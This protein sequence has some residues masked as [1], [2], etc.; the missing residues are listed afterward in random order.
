MI[1]IA[2]LDD[3]QK[4][5]HTFA[6]WGDL[7][8]RAK[9]TFFHD[10]LHDQDALIERLAGFEVICL[11]RERTPF[12]KELFSRL[13]D[14]K[15]LTT[16]GM[17]NA[18]IDLATASE[19]GVTVCGTRSVGH[20]TAEL[21]FAFL[22]NLARNIPAEMKSLE[23]GRWQS[24]VGRDLHGARLG[25]IGLGRLGEL[26]AGY[27]RAFGMD[28]VAWSTNL[29]A[30]VAEERGARK[31][32]KEELFATSE[33]VS[34]HTRLSPR[35]H[36]LVGRAELD[37]M[38]EDAFLINTSRAQI[39]DQTAMIEALKGGRIAG[40][41]LD[42]Y[43]IEPLPDDHP[44]RSVPNLMLTPHI[45]YV[46]RDTY[47]VFYSETLDAIKAWLDGRPIRVIT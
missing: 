24:G 11:M 30:E 15:L 38:R 19:Y 21:A 45:G 3:Y 41:A 16:T 22:L 36:N 20:S 7:D 18:S 35:S 8:G 28:V 4:L 37:L 25:L 14:L 5:A 2:V 9:I 17:H 12:G 13:P 39:V 47:Q 44:L 27:G 1:K 23:A 43:D 46:T 10:T 33:F 29:T 6:P 26:M 31:V 40:A 42:V 32:S 34:I